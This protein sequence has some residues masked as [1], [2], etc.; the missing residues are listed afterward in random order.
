MEG[1]RLF[2]EELE[3]KL[4]RVTEGREQKEV[5]SL[6]AKLQYT[7]NNEKSIFKLQST[8]MLMFKESS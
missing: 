1:E 2:M 4:E 5:M 7:Y 8:E 3:Q 6:K